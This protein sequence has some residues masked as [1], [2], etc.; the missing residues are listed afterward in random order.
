[1]DLWI[2]LRTSVRPSVRSFVP[3]SP[4]IRDVFAFSPKI[5]KLP[6]FAQKWSKIGLFGPKCPK[7]GFLAFF[8]Y[9]KKKKHFFPL[10][11]PKKHSLITQKRFWPFFGVLPGF[12]RFP[13]TSY[14]G[15][16]LYFDNFLGRKTVGSRE[17]P[18]DSLFIFKFVNISFQSR[19][20]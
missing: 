15:L 3:I 6:L 9:L 1:M 13:R 10:I 4:K 12:L 5:R 16:S 7:M 14:G 2:R 19:I 8:F 18:R 20:S 17:T 11:L